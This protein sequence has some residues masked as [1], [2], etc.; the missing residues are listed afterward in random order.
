MEKYLFEINR[1]FTCFFPTKEDKP[2][3]YDNIIKNKIK[4]N[5]KP[6]DHEW[7][8]TLIEL[9]INKE[10]YYEIKNIIG[11]TQIDTIK[12]F[13]EYYIDLFSQEDIDYIGEINQAEIL[14]SEFY[15]YSSMIIDYDKLKNNYDK[16]DP[17][18][19][20]I[21]NELLKEDNIYLKTY[22]EAIEKKMKFNENQL[23][24][25]EIMLKK[26]NTQLLEKLKFYLCVNNRNRQERN[27]AIGYS[28]DDYLK[29]YRYSQKNPYNF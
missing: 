6:E 17:Y 26:A 23:I 13:K 27:V 2:I 29:K 3:N 11:N 28:S 25:K 5:A 14:I 10:N 1:K 21:Y 20:S 19:D 4:M 7:L 15:K 22:T 8:K 18:Y 9:I 16:N 24:L 12:K